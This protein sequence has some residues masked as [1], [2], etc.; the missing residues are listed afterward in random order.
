MEEEGCDIDPPFVGREEQLRKLENA[1]K[2]H[3]I[4]GVFGIR[5][6]G[7]S[8]FV[9]EFLKRNAKH[10]G[11]KT[12]VNLIQVDLKMFLTT[13]ETLVTLMY[14]RLGLMPDAEAIQ[15]GKWKENIA[16]G[17]RQKIREHHVFTVWFDNAEDVLDLDKNVHDQFLSLCVLLVQYCRGIKILVTST[18]K[19]LFTQIR[20]VYFQLEV[21]LLTNL[22]VVQLL[23]SV[24]PG[25][26]YGDFAVPIAEQC[27]GLPLL[28]IMTGSELSEDDGMLEPGDMFELLAENKLRA[29]SKEYYPEEDR[30]GKLDFSRS[31]TWQIT[32]F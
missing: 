17:V 15:N 5:A 18:T 20:R 30:V 19:F 25:V 16:D 3:A 9:K 4:F 2:S 28:I 11:L 24:T 7:K 29:L 31:K 12:D 23:E 8:R 1:W 27:E 14:S 13:V 22:E 21:P 6:V 10:L 26:K 32:L